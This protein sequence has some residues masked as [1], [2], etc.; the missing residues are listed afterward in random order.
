L[1]EKTT[2]ATAVAVAIIVKVCKLRFKALWESFYFW[3]RT[4]VVACMPP[5]LTV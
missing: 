4:V 5:Q 2:N 3:V 1:H